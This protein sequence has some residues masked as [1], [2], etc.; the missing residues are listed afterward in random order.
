MRENSTHMFRTVDKVYLQFSTSDDLFT[1]I[2]RLVDAQHVAVQLDSMAPEQRP[3]VK[4][5]DAGTISLNSAD[6]VYSMET[7]VEL[8]RDDLIIFKSKSTERTQRRKSERSPCSFA[9]DI[10]VE[11]NLIP[12]NKAYVVQAN[13]IDFSTGGCGVIIEK[14][15]P[16]HT[17]VQIAFKDSTLDSLSVH[18]IVCSCRQTEANDAGAVPSYLLGIRYVDLTRMQTLIIIRTVQSLTMPAKESRNLQREKS[19]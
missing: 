15:V 2:I 16:A 17:N 5:G 8:S 1:G 14:L 19:A 12:T 6:G 7:V 11:N 3:K 9:A 10:L 18:G 4:S 13:V